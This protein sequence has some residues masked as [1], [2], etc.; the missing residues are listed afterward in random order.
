MDKIQLIKVLKSEIERSVGCTDPGAVCLAV[1]HAAK[2]LG[3][4]PW[5][6]EV[7]VSPN[8]YKNGMCVGV[9]GTGMRGLHIAAALG[10]VI[11]GEPGLA[12]LDRASAA[13]LA[14]AKSLLARGM[15]SI[16][17]CGNV[18]PAVHQSTGDDRES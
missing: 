7:T 12:M 16:A 15:V 11:G 2:A 3:Q 1:R 8:V 6:V 4:K 18:R 14:D 13:D 5:Q 10:A 17:H 9:P